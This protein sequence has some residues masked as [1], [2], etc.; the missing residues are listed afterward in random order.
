MRYTETGDTMDVLI[1]TFSGL[2]DVHGTFLAPSWQSFMR[3]RCASQWTT[4]E[5]RLA[6]L[7][8]HTPPVRPLPI[9]IDEKHCYLPLSSLRLAE[10]T[11]INVCAVVACY[12]RGY[13]TMIVFQDGHEMAVG[14]ALKAMQSKVRKCQAW[15][16][17]LEGLRQ[18]RFHSRMG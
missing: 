10:V 1:K 16:G 6:F 5:G 4:L 12:A 11:L 13:D 15:L 7:K 9:V 2:Y 8:S 17:A 18:N 14:I 3:S